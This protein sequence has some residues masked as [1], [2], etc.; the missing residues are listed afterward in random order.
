MFED[1]CETSMAE[2]EQAR[3]RAVRNEVG[4]WDCG[5]IVREMGSQCRALSRGH[6]F[7]NW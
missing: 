3:Q 1:N 4:R 6:G 2:I 7:F 5:A